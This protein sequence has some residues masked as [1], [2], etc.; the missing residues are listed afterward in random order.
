MGNTMTLD[1]S[2]IEKKK[3]YK[4]PVGRKGKH[5]YV[6]IPHDTA[7]AEIVYHKSAAWVPKNGI[8]FYIHDESTISR[9]FDAFSRHKGDVDEAAT[10]SRSVRDYE[11]ACRVCDM[12]LS[13]TKKLNI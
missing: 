6:F 9:V 11:A 12:L 5:A 10:A 3:H 4:K 1:L 13:V 8:E 2:M 7:R